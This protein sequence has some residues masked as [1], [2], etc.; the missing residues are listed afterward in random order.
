MLALAASF[1]K[2]LNPPAVLLLVIVLAGVKA[3]LGIIGVTALALGIIAVPGI[4]YKKFP[5][6][7][8]K[9]GLATS[10]RTKVVAALT[11]VGALTCLILDVPGP[12][13]ATAMGL[14]VGNAGLALAR[15]RLNA[16]A[17]VSVLTF[18]VS[19]SV[20][21]FGGEFSWLLVLSPVMLVSRTVLREHTWGEAL[22]GALI[23]IVT[24]GFFAEANTWSWIT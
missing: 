16:S 14:V 11:L 12:V 22:V 8:M 10:L 15:L 5:V 20:A 13:P 23:G 7:A 4:V 18:A 6:L 24:F 3:G 9:L 2:A 1:S 21:V 19:W 17:H